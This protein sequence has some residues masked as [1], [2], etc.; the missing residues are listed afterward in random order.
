MTEYRGGGAEALKSVCLNSKLHG[1]PPK[2][3]LAEVNGTRGKG[4]SDRAVVQDSSR[5]EGHIR[6]FGFLPRPKE[7][8]A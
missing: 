6:I 3:Q 2:F 7:Q 4:R 5:E 1:A 8:R